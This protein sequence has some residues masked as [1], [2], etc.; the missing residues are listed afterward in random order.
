MGLLFLP[1]EI[2]LH[3]DRANGA[4]PLPSPRT[5]L[6]L[7]DPVSPKLTAADH[8]LTRGLPEC[9]LPPRRTVRMQLRH[10][11]QS[12]DLAA[13]DS[14]A[15][16]FVDHSALRSE[17]WSLERGRDGDEGRKLKEALI[18]N[19]LKVCPHRPE[20]N[21]SSNLAPWLPT[22]LPLPGLSLERPFHNVN[23]LTTPH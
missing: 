17:P 11:W 6:D 9:P 16:L 4:H 18:L 23:A 19:L 5:N 7:K 3:K 13:P 1:P 20:S 10:R 21:A 22:G 14:R 8:S 12:L 15:L 2:Q